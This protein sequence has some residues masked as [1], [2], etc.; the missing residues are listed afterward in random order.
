MKSTFFA[1]L[2]AATTGIAGIVQADIENVIYSTDFETDASG[3]FTVVS[4][5]DRTDFVA[6]F[7]YDYSTFSQTGGG[8]P[9]SIPQA[10]STD[11]AVT[12]TTALRLEAN[13]VDNAAPHTVAAFVNGLD[14][15]IDFTAVDFVTVKF[16]LWINYNGAAGGGTGSTEFAITGLMDTT[17]PIESTANGATDP[18]GVN[19]PGV[20]VGTTGE[21]GAGQDY[22]FYEGTATS[23]FAKSDEVNWNAPDQTDGDGDDQSEWVSLFP[24]PT[25][26]TAGAVGKAW[27]V[28]EL[29]Y[30]AQGN[31]QW[32]ITPT[33]GERTLIVSE[34]LNAETPLGSNPFVG[35]MDVFSSLANP[36]ADNFGLIDNLEIT[37]TVL[38]DA[39]SWSLYQ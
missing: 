1:S 21:G 30:S 27:N 5:P 22:R 19:V 17:D 23:G 33:G 7:S 14:T 35:Y 8:V 3:D 26:E 15:A 12:T 13:T 28:V 18:A 32:Y 4:T 25:Y 34:N 24:S 16:D 31:V 10:P 6:N 2:L 20:Y 36:A 29:V 37:T 11:G 39:G 38:T 9:T